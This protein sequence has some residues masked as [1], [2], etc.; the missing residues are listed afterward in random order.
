MLNRN[1]WVLAN[2]L[3]IGPLRG[4]GSNPFMEGCTH[5]IA[6]SDQTSHWIHLG[7]LPSHQKVPR[8]P[9]MPIPLGKLLSPSTASKGQIEVALSTK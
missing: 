4:S 5:S 9:L 1:L 8:L 6:L 7:Q 3:K 2:V